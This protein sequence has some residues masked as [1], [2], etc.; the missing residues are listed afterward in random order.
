MASQGKCL[1]TILTFVC[2]FPSG[3]FQ[4]LRENSHKSIFLKIFFRLIPDFFSFYDRY[5]INLQNYCF[6]FNVKLQVVVKID[7][8]G[9]SGEQKTVVFSMISF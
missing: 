1:V 5:N 9:N 8:K 4:I 2:P 6:S 7:M 3:S